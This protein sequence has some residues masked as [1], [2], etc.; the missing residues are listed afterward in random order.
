MRLEQKESLP[1][2]LDRILDKGIVIEARVRASL[3]EVELLQ[4]NATIIL[5][6]F[7]SA[8]FHGLDLPSGIN[9]ETKAWRAL[10]TKEECPN[11][12]KML[13]IEELKLG[14]PWCGYKD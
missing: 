3:K 12:S 5:S 9:Y 6:S 13:E 7:K 4:V 8:V 2:V 11:C 14:C 10:L 1:E